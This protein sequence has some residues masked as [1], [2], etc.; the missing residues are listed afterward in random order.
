MSLVFVSD[1]HRESFQEIRSTLPDR[2]KQDI[3]HISLIYL[4]TGN[5][6]LKRK[7]LPY[8]KPNEGV[9][10]FGDMFR[11]QDFSS[12]MRVLAK[13]AVFL[14]NMGEDVTLGELFSL[15]SFNLWLAR[16]AIKLR[17]TGEW[18]KE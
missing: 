8:Y 6:E 18:A 14:F 2:Y 10:L 15:D 1:D 16:E 12:G 11:E 4:L 17:R 3:E 13:L 7:A 5:E 9:F